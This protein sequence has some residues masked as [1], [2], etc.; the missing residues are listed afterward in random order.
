MDVAE[1]SLPSL[2]EGTPPLAGTPAGGGA[3]ATMEIEDTQP[4]L[5]VVP[6]E[7]DEFSER[8]DSPTPTPNGSTTPLGPSWEETILADEETK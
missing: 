5:A 7:I 4:A 1:D 8:D 3:T 6:S 2:V